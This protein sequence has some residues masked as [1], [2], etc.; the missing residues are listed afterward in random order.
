MK[1]LTFLDKHAIIVA[2]LTFFVVSYFLM[3]GKTNGSSTIPVE[4]ALIASFVV[5]D[6]HLI[7]RKVRNN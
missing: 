3:Y 1:F 7:A 6:A 2:V 5:Y 4:L